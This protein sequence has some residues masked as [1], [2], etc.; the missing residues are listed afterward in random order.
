M[1]SDDEQATDAATTSVVAEKRRTARI[2]RRSKAMT[3]PAGREQKRRAARVRAVRVTLHE[4]VRLAFG[5]PLLSEPAETVDAEVHPLRRE[6]AAR[7]AALMTM[8]ERE[9]ARR[10]LGER[11]ARFFEDRFLLGE[12]IA[13]LDR[14]DGRSARRARAFARARARRLDGLGH[15]RGHRGELRLRRRRRYI[16]IRGGRRAEHSAAARRPG[17]APPARPHAG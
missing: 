13:R 9:S 15:R 5:R 4:R 17:G 3:S 7:E 12:P 10:I 14:S 1:I 6:L 11:L 2:L 8:Q 16:A